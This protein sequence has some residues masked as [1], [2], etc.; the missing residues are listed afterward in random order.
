MIFPQYRKYSNNKKYYKIVSTSELE[1]ISFI[2]NK[3]I[4]HKITAKILPDRNLIDD[5]LNDIPNSC[6]IATEEEYITEFKKVPVN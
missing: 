1:E 2:G 5:L 3:A 6:L 4:L